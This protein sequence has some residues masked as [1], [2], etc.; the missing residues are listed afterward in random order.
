MTAVRSNRPPWWREI[1][2]GLALFGVY[3]LVDSLGGS[4]RRAAAQAHG[5][6]I[7]RLEG[8]LHLD[9]GAAANHWLA[10]HAVLSLLADYEYATTYI[11]SALVTFVWVYRRRPE[12]YRFARDSFIALNLVGMACFVLYPVAPPRLLPGLGLVDT[13]SRAHTWGSWGSPLVTHANQLAAMPSLHVAWSVW[14]SLVLARVAA[15]RLVQVLGLAHV[16]L[17]VAVIVATANHFVLDAV[18]GAVAVWMGAWAADRWRRLRGVP[19]GHPVPSADA[20]FWHV[21]TAGAP[22]H[23]GGVIMLEPSGG[24]IGLPTLESVR[25]VVGAALDSL[26]RF[27][28]RL[29]SGS[30]WRRPVWVDVEQP[31]LGWHVHEHVLPAPGGRDALRAYVAQVA[32]RP[33]PAD[34]P[35][36][37]VVIVRR[38]GGGQSAMLFLV[39]HTIADGIGIVVHAL[40]L[41][42]PSF[43][44]PGAAPARPAWAGR[45]FGTAVGLAQLATDGTPKAALSSGTSPD[46]SFG[47]VSI[48][49]QTMRSVAAACHCRVTDVLLSGVAGAITRVHPELAARVGFRLRVAVPSLLRAPGAGAE[50][51]VTSAVMVDLPLDAM[52]ERER[53]TR[54]AA[55]T[56]RLRTPTRALGSRFVM[57]HVLAVVPEPAASWFARTVYGR[58]FFHAIVSN[59]P[60][61][62]EQLHMAGV[63]LRDVLPVVPLAPGAPI[64]VGALGWNGVFGVGLTSDPAVFDA[65]LLCDALGTIVAGLSAA[66]TQSSAGGPHATARKS[67]ARRSGSSIASPSTSRSWPSR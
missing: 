15:P 38:V 35:L 1:V 28:Q 25:A 10:P 58:R 62:T 42:R 7:D 4:A 43:V 37:R 14:V 59:M 47:M 48:D 2:L 19:V 22:Q 67:R 34:R 23:V 53:L 55:V 3:V 16:A 52:P 64:A 32:A 66:D 54:V 13:V 36:W 65:Q 18:G 20:F 21:E 30:R 29:V 26:P 11:V 5:L 50:G 17:T 41:F 56:S 60:G 24:E 8:W 49:L 33:M 44:L 27:R 57:A 31:D 6:S 40:Q 51:N 63:P 9:V 39:H 46:R 61:P 12:A 45:G